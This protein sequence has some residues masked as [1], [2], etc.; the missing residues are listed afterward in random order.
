MVS[1][2]YP[3]NIVDYKKVIH[4]LKRLKQNAHRT[5]LPLSL[6]NLPNFGAA[7]RSAVRSKSP[8]C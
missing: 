6:R 7:C 3:L 2:Y 5:H 8:N 4:H 1:R